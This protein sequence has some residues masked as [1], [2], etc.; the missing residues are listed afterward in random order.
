MELHVCIMSGKDLPIMGLLRSINP[1]IEL[2]CESIH[3][4][5][6]LFKNKRNPT[7]NEQFTFPIE[8]I[9]G[10]LTLTLKNIKHQKAKPCSKFEIKIK[11]IPFGIILDQWIDLNSLSEKRKGGML[12]VKFHLINH[13]EIP[14]VEYALNNSYPKH[15]AA[16]D[17]SS[18]PKEK[19]F[20]FDD[21]TLGIELP[22]AFDRRKALTP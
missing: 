15:I 5:T 6:Q 8:K 7:W 17:S 11:E 22:I 4:E 10:K 1:L 21:F 3:H 18:A 2:D 13:G 9:R 14:F 20:F 12:H 19:P 16:E